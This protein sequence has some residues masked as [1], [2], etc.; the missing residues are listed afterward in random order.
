MRNFLTL[1]QEVKNCTL[2]ENLP[3]G[4]KPILQ[5]S[6]SAKIL[7]VGQAPGHK[8]HYQGMPFTDQSGIRLREW[9]G[10]NLHTFYDPSQIAILP[11]G[12]CFPGTGASG[13]LPP[14]KECARHWRDK[15]LRQLTQIEFT[16]IIGQYAID[17]HLGNQQKENL[18]RTV[19]AWRE[20][21]PKCVVL[22]HPSPRNNRWFK[23]NPWFFQEIIPNLQRRV[24]ELIK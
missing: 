18:T 11:M 6:P 15:L 9:L 13:D 16:I 7:I 19:L 1:L 8:T 10:I 24:K 3:L 12:F 5:I 21:W 20:Y 14:R 22:P 4:P 17:W 23:A 2:C